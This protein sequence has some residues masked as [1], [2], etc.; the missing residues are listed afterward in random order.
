MLTCLLTLDNDIINI[1]SREEIRKQRTSLTLA[2]A[3]SNSY[4]HSRMIFSQ[5]NQLPQSFGP[6]L[7]AHLTHEIHVM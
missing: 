6:M 7:H 1:A 5:N 4:A 3:K 2:N